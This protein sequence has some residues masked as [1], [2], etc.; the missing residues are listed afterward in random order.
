[1]LLSVFLIGLSAFQ[2]NSSTIADGYTNQ[3]SVHAGDSIE[4]YL[5]A[6]QDEP[7]Q[8]IR[9][10][11]LSGKEVARYTVAIIVQ[12]TARRKPWENGFNY[13]RSATVFIPNTLKSG[14]YLWE[15]S[16][17]LII[18][19][20]HPKIVVVYPSNT[21]NAYNVAGGKSLYD[22]NSTNKKRAEKV[23]FLRPIPLTYHAEEFLRW[24]HKQD[25]SDVGY[26]TD[27]DLDNYPEIKKAELLIIPGHS[28]YWTLAA[29]KNFDRFVNDGKNA[30]ILSGNTMWWQVRYNAKKDQLICYRDAKDDPIKSAKLKTINWNEPQLGYSILGS[31]G[32]D[33]SFGGYGRKQDKGWDGYKI[34][35]RSPLLEGTSLIKGSILALASDE[36]DGAPIAAFEQNSIPRINRQALGFERIELVGFDLVMRGGKEGVATWI[37]FKRT[38]SSGIIINT[39]STDW[40]SYR[41]IGTNPDI[42]KIT[43]TMISKLL[44]KENVFG[45]DEDILMPPVLLN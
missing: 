18:K 32:A 28:E 17:P 12:D 11:D 37:V 25:L 45:P 34:T 40:C 3:L 44:K 43:L 14:V 16:I 39:A 31:I 15:N 42:Q 38:K 20:H 23:S 6:Y 13:K 27:M 41:G 24:M 30:L 7:H 19:S 33:F 22:F 29:R 36:A 1:M 35:S 21:E 8:L 10:F 4:L 26:I 9:L 5:N 2:T